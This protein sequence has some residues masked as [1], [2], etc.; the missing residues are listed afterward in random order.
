[1]ILA[2]SGYPLVSSFP[3]IIKSLNSPPENSVVW[4]LGYIFPYPWFTPVSW[5]VIL[6][7][8]AGMCA[9]KVYQSYSNQSGQLLLE[10]LSLTFLIM[11][12]INPWFKLQYILLLAISTVFLNTVLYFMYTITASIFFLLAYS[13][14]ELFSFQVASARKL[15][16]LF[17]ISVDQLFWGFLALWGGVLLIQALLSWIEKKQKLKRIYNKPILPEN[18]EKLHKSRKKI[19]IFVI[20]YN[21]SSKI[22]ETMSRIPKEIYKQA[23]EIFII[24][25][26]SSDTTYEEALK[27]KNSMKKFNINVLRNARNKGYGGNQKVGY[28]YAINKNYDIVVMLHA[29]GQYAPEVMASLLNPLIENKAD[30]VFGSRMA[31]NQTPL[32]GGMPFYKYIGNIILTFIENIFS[33]MKLS[34]FHSGY[35]AFSCHALK[36]LPFYLNSN[37]WHFDTEI[38]LQFHAARMR[39]REV[40]IPTFYVDEI[41]Y[42]NG[43]SYGINCILSVLLYRL[44]KWRLWHIIKYEP[45]SWQY[46][47]YEQKINDPFSTQRFAIEFVSRTLQEKSKSRNLLEIGS[48]RKVLAEHFAHL[49]YNVTVVESNPK[50]INLIKPYA[51]K[52]YNKNVEELNWDKMEN[53][54]C[55]VLA[56]ILEH[57]EDPLD[58]LT[59]CVNH[60]KENGKIIITFPNIGHWSARISF[61]FGHFKYKDRGIF[62]KTN[63]KFFSKKSA[64]DLLQ[65]AGLRVIDAKAV[66]IPLPLFFPFLQEKSPFVFIHA[67]NYIITQIWQ[68]LFAYQWVFY[69]EPVPGVRTGRLRMEKMAHEKLFEKRMSD[70]T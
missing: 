44:S 47:P 27:F 70:Y 42:V 4:G 49:G 40:P 18:I 46:Y 8:I 62:E 48:R 11:V 13:P 36:Q 12:I 3:D 15:E 64:I 2:G 35:R 25:D 16:W 26:C 19:A 51:K 56:E 65:K 41:C 59:N 38:L 63:L 50:F 33:G 14:G 5:F 67:I 57:L 45:E 37:S 52:I 30:M 22:K 7:F 43:I 20:A 53:F 66:P 55:I 31:K 61:L 10:I 23:S 60:L 6:F 54:D 24:D 28:N 58:C 29:D 69:S 17:N 34:E 1:M 32:K 68:T 39:L 21:A 9:R